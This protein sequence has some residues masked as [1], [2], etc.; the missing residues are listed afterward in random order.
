MLFGIAH[1]HGTPSGFPGMALTFIGGWVFGFAMV[2][3][4]WW[5]AIISALAILGILIARAYDDHDK[6]ILPA[7]TV[8]YIVGDSDARLVIGDDARL[9]L[10]PDSVPKLSFYRDWASFIEEGL[11]GGPF[12]AVKMKPE[13]DAMFFA[14]DAAFPHA[15]LP[16]DAGLIVTEGVFSMDGDR[17]PLDKLMAISKRHDAWLMVDDAHG[18]GVLGEHGAGCVEG[19]DSHSVPILVGTLGKAFG[20]LGAFVVGPPE[21]RTLLVSAGRS[22]IFSTALP[23]PPAGSETLQIDIPA[24]IVSQDAYPPDFDLAEIPGGQQW[25]G[26]GEPRVPFYNA[27]FNYPTLAE[28]YKVA[29][30]AALEA[31]ESDRAE[32][33]KSSLLP[34]LAFGACL[35]VPGTGILL[36]DTMDDF[37]AA[38]GI[39]NQ[40]GLVEG[41]ANAVASGK[42]P[43]SSMAPTILLKDGRPRMV[44]GSPGGARIITT[45]ISVL[46]QNNAKY[47]AAGICNGGGGAS[48]V[49]IE[50][51]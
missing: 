24:Y 43:L 47:G 27:V 29:A 22:F 19:F 31:R 17:A 20:S 38:P 26:P 49:V 2:W 50:R 21:L 33:R 7:E 23:E 9:A 37:S 48:A 41:E 35:V 18:L 13:E 39:P 40:F 3:Y 44:L 51:M 15:M 25:S 12:T 1:Y 8:A 30:L 45:L 10:A 34:A 16:A 42:T 11:Q 6:Q 36:N 32:G 5:L 46:Q 14:V 4:I 28:C